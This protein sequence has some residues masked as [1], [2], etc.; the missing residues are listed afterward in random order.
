MG[1]F[2]FVGG[3]RLADQSIDL[4]TSSL[5]G[6]VV[7]RPTNITTL[8]RRCSIFVDLSSTREALLILLSLHFVCDSLVCSLL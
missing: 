5:F 8:K 1:F 3:E 7:G 4:L 6:V 2:L